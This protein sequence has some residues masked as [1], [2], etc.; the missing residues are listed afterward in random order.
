MYYAM[1]SLGHALQAPQRD[2]ATGAPLE[3][4]ACGGN[5]SRAPSGSSL[6]R[7]SSG[8]AP[9]VPSTAEAFWGALKKVGRVAGRAEQMWEAAGACRGG[10]C[11][12]V[13]SGST[14]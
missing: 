10:L 7:A 11:I 12:D 5:L 4:S 14:L 3:R 13:L 6:S 2:A 9:A 1:R 8:P